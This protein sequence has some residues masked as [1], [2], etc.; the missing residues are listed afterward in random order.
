MTPRQNIGGIAPADNLR[1]LQ[2][3]AYSLFFG[4]DPDAANPLLDR[5]LNAYSATSEGAA[6]A[7]SIL[8]QMVTQLH[9][10]LQIKRSRIVRAQALRIADASGDSELM[11][12]ERV[13][14]AGTLCGW[15]RYSE[16]EALLFNLGKI[17][18]QDS[19]SFASAYCATR[20]VCSAASG[21]AVEAYKDFDRAVS[22]SKEDQNFYRVSVI[23]QTYAYWAQLLGNTELAKACIE[24][25]LLVAR[26]G[27][28]KWY[29]PAI[30]LEY[31]ELLF[32]MGHSQRAHEFLVEAVSFPSTA[33]LTQMRFATT[34]I[35]IALHMRDSETLTKC[36]NETLI[37]SVLQSE[38][39]DKID[40][41]SASYAL[42][43]ATQGRLDKARELLHRALQLL[44]P[45]RYVHVFCLAVAQYGSVGDLPQAR[46]LLTTS[47][48][49]LRSSVVQAALS[50]F[51][52]FVAQRHGNL[53]EAQRCAI[54][55][56]D[57]FAA[58]HLYGL[59]NSALNLV[60][61]QKRLVVPHADVDKQHHGLY[62]VLTHREREVA[63]FALK[64]LTNREIAARLTIREHTVEKHMSSIMNRLDIRSRYQL[65]EA[66]AEALE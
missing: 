30:C 11:R 45:V 51:D 2:K 53:A 48:Q 41:F 44:P 19:P 62:H 8:N 38:D 12:I 23:W 6:K 13:R 47:L 20:A 42:F 9:L 58:L 31:A 10:G 43:Y 55:A 16:A 50:L 27:Q 33:A 32:N 40:Q 5:L 59:A 14:M 39:S 64:G 63:E 56:R 7:L 28:I 52:A 61:D 26:R 3:L 36:V 1:I 46:Y 17:S 35:P 65:P 29:I 60:P 24:R 4:D 57:S 34:G 49:V 18:E 25:A 66:L 54:E 22:Y 21:N 15:N 37:D